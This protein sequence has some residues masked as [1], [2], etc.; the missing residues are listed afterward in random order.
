MGARSS[1]RKRLTRVVSIIS[2]ATSASS[3]QGIVPAQYLVA[4]SLRSLEA[5]GADGAPWGASLTPNFQSKQITLYFSGW[6]W[7]HPPTS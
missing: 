1:I 7:P 6:M 4:H 3:R 2:D 5:V